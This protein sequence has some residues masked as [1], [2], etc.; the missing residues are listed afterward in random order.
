MMMKQTLNPPSRWTG[1]A[2]ASAQ[3]STFNAQ[4]SYARSKL[5]V[6]RWTLGVGR[7]LRA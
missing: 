2:V 6:G 4:L 3:R 7:F 1:S 5:E